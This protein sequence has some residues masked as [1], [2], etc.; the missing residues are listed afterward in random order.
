MFSM[1]KTGRLLSTSSQHQPRLIPPVS[2]S[3]KKPLPHAAIAAPAAAG[4]GLGRGRA[5][6]E[7]ACG[8]QR[9]QGLKHRLRGVA[10]GQ[11]VLQPAQQFCLAVNGGGGW[12]RGHARGILM[13]RQGRFGAVA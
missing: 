3:L 5:Q 11:G 9:L 7:A 13:L 10:V 8:G 6:A 12:V 4:G 1:R 2:R